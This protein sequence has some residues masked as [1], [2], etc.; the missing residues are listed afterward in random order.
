MNSWNKQVRSLQILQI[1]IG[2]KNTNLNGEQ[3]LDW[4]QSDRQKI[5]LNEPNPQPRRELLASLP[6]AKQRKELPLGLEPTPAKL[7]LP[8]TVRRRRERGRRGR[9][10]RWWPAIVDELGRGTESGDSE[11]EMAEAGMT[12]EWRRAIAERN[13]AS[14]FRLPSCALWVSLLLQFWPQNMFSLFPNPN[15]S[16]SVKRQILAVHSVPIFSI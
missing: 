6:D 3:Q 4:E 15:F 2:T 5:Q 11:V 16:L 9:Q 13:S 12:V 14:S 7:G 8:T 10:R 1:K